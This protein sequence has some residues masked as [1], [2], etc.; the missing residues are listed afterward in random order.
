MLR[1]AGY[2]ARVDQIFSDAEFDINQNIA[3]LQSYA[4]RVY[5]D[6]EDSRY[7]ANPEAR[8]RAIDQLI[9]SGVEAAQSPTSRSNLVEGQINALFEEYRQQGPIAASGGRAQPIINNFYIEGSVLSE[10]DLFVAVQA[11]IDRG[12]IQP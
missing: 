8:Q 5:G 11:G 4:E 1:E 7:I 9:A 6:P 3:G 10:T 2:G 12:S